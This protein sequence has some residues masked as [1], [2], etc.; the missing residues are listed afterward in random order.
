MKKNFL[1]SVLFC[2]LT[3]FGIVSSVSA[4][5]LLDQIKEKGY[6]TVA[7]EGT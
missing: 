1:L 3:I 6:M 4:A 7:Q 5:D 2:V